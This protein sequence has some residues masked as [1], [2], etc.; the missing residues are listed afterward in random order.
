[1]HRLIVGNSTT[2]KS[3]LAKRFAH[4]AHAR[5]QNV[6]VYDP[7]AS[8]D[9]PD[10]ATKFQSPEQFLSHVE[11]A[12]SAHVFVDEAKTL[13]DT[14]HK[15]ADALLYRRRHQGLLVYVIAQRTRM[16]PPNARNQCS[17]IYAFRQQKIDADILRDEYHES[18]T[19]AMRLKAGHFIASD[20]F[21]FS[22][23]A[24]DYAR[25][26]PPSIIPAE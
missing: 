17:V 6:I 25:G 13:W 1:M 20:G 23:M 11:K 24:L 26:M 5:G 14:D 21:T 22:R 15:R 3:N 16:V 10:S 12:Q 9:W 4:D 18:L 2:G 7:L 8:R 19:D